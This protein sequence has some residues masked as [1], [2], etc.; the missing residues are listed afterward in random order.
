MVHGNSPPVSLHSTRDT[1]V[2]ERSS[3]K[4]DVSVSGT[5]EI[6]FRTHTDA[7]R[8]VT[9]FIPK[10]CELT[11]YGRL[12]ISGQSL[13]QAFLGELCASSEAG[14][15]TMLSALR[16][17]LCALLLCCFFS[18]SVFAGPMPLPS[19]P[20]LPSGEK[21]YDVG[22]T[23]PNLPEDLDY[24]SIPALEQGELK[25]DAER[26]KVNRYKIDYKQKTQRMDSRINERS[27]LTR[28]DEFESEEPAPE[29][30][31]RER[32]SADRTLGFGYQRSELGRVGFDSDLRRKRQTETR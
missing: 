23:A 21:T 28:S 30:S 25:P 24:L 1:E 7:P 16:L 26:V 29:P 31:A 12:P 2:T 10:G 6:L 13:R 3:W 15:Y 8:G 18:P 19:I 17:A 32:S 5:V 20:N 14:G 11:G 9:M 27:N 4:K 22:G